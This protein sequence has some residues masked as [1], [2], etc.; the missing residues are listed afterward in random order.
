VTLGDSYDYRVIV[1]SKD[2]KTMSG[3]FLS[4]TRFEE[5]Q[6]ITV[7]GQRCLV[8]QV[9]PEPHASSGKPQIVSLRC[10]AVDD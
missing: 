5:G 8:S 2:G 4:G 6:V 1:E 7:H 9:M 10:F 3:K